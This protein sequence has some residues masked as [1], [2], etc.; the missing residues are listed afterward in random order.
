MKRLLAILPI[1][2]LI[3]LNACADA[4]ASAIAPDIG[5]KVA[6]TQTASMWTP[7]ITPIP[8]P[9]EPKIVEWLNEGLSAADPLERSLVANYQARDVFFPAAAGSPPTVFRVDIRCDCA[10]S[11]QCCVPEQMFVLTM[12]AMKN[13]TDKIIE[14]VPNS[15][16]EVKVVCFNHEVQ[17]AVLAASWSDAR[18]YLLD[19]I[20]GYQLGSRVYWSNLP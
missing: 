20:N 4:S 6:Q 11:T 17:F 9:N 2:L 15:V 13:R 5:T 14:Q 8:D 3:L 18:G 19:Q 10:F 12:L 1:F 16:S 7:T